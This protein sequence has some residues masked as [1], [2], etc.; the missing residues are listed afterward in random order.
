M[1]RFLPATIV[2]FLLV[3]ATSTLAA[4][5]WYKVTVN[6][7]GDK[8]Y[9]DKSSVQRQGNVVRYWEYREF[10]QANKVFFEEK[11]DRPLHGVVSFW[12][13]DCT[14]RLGRMRKAIA[15]DKDRKVIREF[16]YGDGAKPIQVASNSSA[17]KVV[18]YACSP[19][20]KP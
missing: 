3:T 19:T 4:V 7:V 17:G 2:G 1:A 14:T 16:N 8:F 6:A 5:E 12:T 11:L 20:A 10:P 13:T 18:D 9:I 15:Y